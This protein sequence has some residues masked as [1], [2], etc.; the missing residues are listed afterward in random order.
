MSDSINNST[1]LISAIIPA[2]NAADTITRTL[3]S[4]LDQT[5]PPH[6]IIV[7]DDGSQDNTCEVVRALGDRVTLISQENGGPSAARNTGIKAATGDWLAFLDSDDAWLPTKLERQIPHLSDEYAIV[8]CY[9]VDGADEHDFELT[10]DH[11]WEHNYIGTSTVILKKSAWESI[12]G[13]KEERKYIGIED[14]NLW[15]R[16]LHEGGRVKTVPEELVLYTPDEYSI[17]SIYANA[18]RAELFHVGVIG[19]ELSIAPDRIKKKKASLYAEYGKALF[20]KRDLPLAR[21]YYGKL[22]TNRPSMEAGM[23]WLATFLPMSILNRKRS[24]SVA[25]ES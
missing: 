4:I 25:K 5:V 6:E 21:K 10:F 19:E 1:P 20:W 14:Y 13:F 22:M 2:Y 11:L 8:D 15:L 7:V 12:G 9:E 16:I 18:I 24:S 23:Y 3:K 17:S